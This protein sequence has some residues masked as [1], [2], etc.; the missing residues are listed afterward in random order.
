MLRVLGALINLLN[1][2]LPPFLLDHSAVGPRPGYLPNNLLCFSC[3][4]LTIVSALNHKY[5][6]Q[7]L[8][9]LWDHA[10]SGLADL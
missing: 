5:T 8:R 4:C 3:S 10:H 9:A 1:P 2:R 7:G 6:L